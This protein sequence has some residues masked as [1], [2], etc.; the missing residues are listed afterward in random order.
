MLVAIAVTGCGGTAVQLNIPSKA[1]IKRE[2][3]NTTLRE[4]IARIGKVNFL[5]ASHPVEYINLSE[6]KT[7]ILTDDYWFGFVN[8]A[9][10]KICDNVNASKLP[11]RKLL[12]HLQVR[13]RFKPQV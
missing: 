9:L 4:K 11:E 6:S 12:T 5:Y 13:E 10:R 8:N 3:G 7:A 2:I 1:V